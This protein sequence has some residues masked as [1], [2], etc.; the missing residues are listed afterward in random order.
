MDSALDILQK[1]CFNVCVGEG[2]QRRPDE[3]LGSSGARVLCGCEL[4]GL[5]AENRIGVLQKNNKHAQLWSHLFRPSAFGCNPSKTTATFQAT[6]SRVVESAYGFKFLF[7]YL[8]YNCSSMSSGFTQ[9]SLFTTGTRSDQ[10]SS[11]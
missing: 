10:Y 2:L 6:P 8:I 3:G 4:L 11:P 1:I 9:I 7:A 5:G